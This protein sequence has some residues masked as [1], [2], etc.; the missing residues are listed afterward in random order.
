MCALPLKIVIAGPLGSSGGLEVHTGELESFL[1]SQGHRV[2]RINII[3]QNSSNG[4]AYRHIS[5]SNVAGTK[6]KVYKVFDWLKACFLTRLFAPDLLISTAIGSGYKWLSLFAGSRT[7]RIVQIVTDDYPHNDAGML[8]L[9]QAYD[10]VAAQT[11]ILKDQVRAKISP[12][13]SCRV[14]PCFHQIHPASRESIL[15]QTLPGEIRLA[16]FGRLA[17]NKGLSLLL[18]AWAQLNFSPLPKLDIW[19]SGNLLSNLEEKVRIT[20][21]LSSSVTLKGPYPCGP[22][23]IKLLSSY[24]GLVLPSQS[25]EGLPL[26][27]LEAASVGL[28]ILTSTVGGIPDFANGNPDVIMVDIGLQSLAIGLNNFICFIHNGDKFD[29]SRHKSLFLRQYS[30]PA[31]ESA[32]SRVLHSP[33][34]FFSA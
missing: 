33:S 16:Y 3:S 14:L 9:V 24:Q 32:W 1:V 7:F 22:E 19:G 23:Y 30:R 27:L 10:A 2:L 13:V 25:T 8:S 18:D 17:G 20:S 34:S 28:P 6:G 26:V 11:S 15:P 29:R 21:S 5:I 4:N 12:T 31:I